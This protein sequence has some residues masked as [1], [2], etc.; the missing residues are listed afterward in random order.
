MIQEKVNFFRKST[1]SGKFNIF[2]YFV[3]IIYVDG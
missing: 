2:Q 3:N 1:D